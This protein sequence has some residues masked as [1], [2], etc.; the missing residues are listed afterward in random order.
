MAQLVDGHVHVHQHG[1][2]IHEGRAGI[3]P[4]QLAR[5]ALGVV[6]REIPPVDDADR[7]VV[8]VDHRHGVQVLVFDEQP[9]HVVV[10]VF[11]QQGR[12]R[13]DPQAGRGSA[14]RALRH[15]GGRARA[16]RIA[17]RRRQFGQQRLV[18]HAQEPALRV[19]DVQ[20]AHHRQV[21]G[22]FDA[23]GNDR[24]AQVL[25]DLQ[26]GA[27][28]VLLALIVADAVKEITVDLDQL[29]LG[30]R[31][32]LQIG[33][34]DAV[35][36]ERDAHAGLAQAG[37]CVVQ[38]AH[39]VRQRVL[40]GELDDDAARFECAILEQPGRHVVA[41]QRPVMEQGRSGQVEEQLAGGVVLFKP[42]RPGAEAGQFEL[43]MQ[44]LAAR[45]GKQGVGKVQGSVGGAADQAFVAI[46]TAVRQVD[47]RLE[48]G[49]QQSFAQDAGQAGMGGRSV[50]WV[51]ECAGRGR[52]GQSVK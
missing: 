8:A 3:A 37:E 15:R 36:V 38:L 9:V 34:A 45:L 50:G 51:E 30:F 52:P 18:G 39:A 7:P 2:G 40:F 17:Q 31:P 47:H 28:H 32:E 25:R 29:G 24:G 5:V 33:I 11:G 23:F 42:A 13:L 26:N 14:R 41:P 12:R 43:R 48:A 1:L 4:E 19:A 21:R 49:P 6:F 16:Q 10:G 22:G 27:H 20:L 44:P 35:V 46:D